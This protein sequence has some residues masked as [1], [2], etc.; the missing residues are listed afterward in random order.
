VSIPVLQ[1]GMC[2]VLYSR[3]SITKHTTQKITTYPILGLFQNSD[4][5]SVASGN[6]SESIS[7]QSDTIAKLAFFNSQHEP[8]MDETL[9]L[10]I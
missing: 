8:L 6:I 1:E 5:N 7:W 9:K 10:G 3:S 4:A 2:P